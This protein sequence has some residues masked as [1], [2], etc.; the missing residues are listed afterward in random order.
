VT[1]RGCRDFAHLVGAFADG[2]LEAG[3]QLDVEAHVE[4]CGGCQERVKLEFAT[5]ASLKRAVRESASD[6]VRAR[7]TAAM[8][9]Q[10]DRS[11]GQVVAQKKSAAWRTVVPLASAAA[12]AL[13]WSAMSRG[14]LA[15]TTAT[16]SLH[17][18][19]G[20]DLLAELVAEHGRPS[21]PEC[22]NPK[23][24][25]QLEQFVGVP[26]RAATLQ[27]Q[28]A[29]LVGGCVLPVRRE[30]AAMLRYELS[31]GG[32]TRRVSIIVFDPRRIQ[33]SDSELEARPVGTAQVRVGRSNGYSVAVTQRA[34]VGYALASDMDMGKTAELA[35]ATEE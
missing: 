26:V 29:K 3:R 31:S 12:F 34:G 10:T 21:P 1:V 15:R 25:G 33:V 2:Q 17:A 30:R 35:L 11:A 7:V 9:A 24:V 32:E 14:P 6:A 5:R 28:H 4:G 27:G 8:R 13:A 22:T 20:D 23:N 19:F 16:S 18:G